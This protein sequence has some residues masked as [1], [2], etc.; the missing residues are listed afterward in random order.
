MSTKLYQ[1]DLLIFILVFSS[2]LVFYF[3]YIL[4][5]MD[6]H[7]MLFLGFGYLMA[8]LRKYGY[9]SIAFNFLIASY[10]LELALLV[11]GAIKMIGQGHKTFEIDLTR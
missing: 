10:V 11:N 7:C 3:I 4:V 5:F 1:K 6:L 8:F 9:S 2:K